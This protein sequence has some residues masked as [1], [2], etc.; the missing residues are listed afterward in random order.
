VR[1]VY[2][3]MAPATPPFMLA[4]DGPITASEVSGF[5]SDVRAALDAGA[6]F[7]L[8]DLARAA[9]DAVTVDVLAR[10]QLSARRLGRRIRSRNASTEL[11]ELVSFMGLSKVLLD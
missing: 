8:C 7:V 10:L 6:P 5:C 3:P 2:L 9:P 4:L 1:A 11:R